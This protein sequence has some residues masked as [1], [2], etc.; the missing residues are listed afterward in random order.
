[1]EKNFLLIFSEMQN[2][3]WKCRILGE[4]GRF[5]NVVDSWLDKALQSACLGNLLNREWTSKRK[6]R[7]AMYA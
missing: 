1:V 6:R 2:C 5:Y 7:Y 3:S 4:F